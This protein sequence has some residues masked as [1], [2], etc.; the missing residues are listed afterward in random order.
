MFCDCACGCHILP[1]VCLH[2]QDSR[3][4]RINIGEKPEILNSVNTFILIGKANNGVLGYDCFNELCAAIKRAQS[5]ADEYAA[6]NPNPAR[7]D[8][9]MDYLYY[10]PDN[11]KLLLLNPFFK[12]MYAA[13]AL[14]YYYSQGHSDAETTRD[15]DVQHQRQGN[16]NLG[17]STKNIDMAAAAKKTASAYNMAEGYFA[18]FVNNFWLKNKHRY[19]CLPPE[20]NCS[21]RGECFSCRSES[22]VNLDKQQQQYTRP[23]ANII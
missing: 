11:W 15:G 19:S 9:K 16:L 22:R 21:P 23:R 3:L 7:N 8:P 5:E 20:N 13:Y 4:K 17:D 12:Q 10:M 18:T 1:P 14:Y 6:D 2:Q